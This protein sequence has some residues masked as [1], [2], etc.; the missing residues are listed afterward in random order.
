MLIRFTGIPRF[1]KVCFLPLC[2]S[3]IFISTC[4]PEWKEIWREFLLLWKKVKIVFGLFCNELL[5]RHWVPLAVREHH[6]V[7]SAGF[8]LNIS[9]S[10]HSSFDLCLWASM[11]SLNL[12]CASVSEMYSKVL[13][14]CFAPFWLVKVCMG[15]PFFWISGETCTRNVWENIWVNW[16]G[17]CC[18]SMHSSFLQSELFKCPDE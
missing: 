6:G 4:F 13:L 1:L 14:L 5:E 11:I 9:T 16:F 3:K 15:M 8:I 17:H 7:P 18:L 2:L 10:S 12:L